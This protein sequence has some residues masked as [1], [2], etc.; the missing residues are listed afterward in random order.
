[1]AL[2]IAAIVLV[3]AIVLRPQPLPEAQALPA[4][5]RSI[6]TAQLRPAAAF[7][8]ITDPAVRSVALFE[9]AGRVIQHPRCMNC[10]PR[11]DRPTQTDA[12]RPH[13]PW[14]TR[15]PDNA[16]AA[17]LRCTTCHHDANFAASGVPGNPKW[18]LAPIEMAWQG[19]TL[20]QICRQILDPARAHMGRDQLLQHMAK[21]EL[22]GWAWHPG[23]KRTPAP[24]TQ[25]E[26]GALIDAWLK[27]GAR[28]PA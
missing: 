20:G 18:K 12:M 15:G 9:E 26:F 1:M 10:H 16:G 17:T 23:G 24:G 2:V 25:A 3:L 27:T 21:D 11:T 8:T 4:N 5:H 13:M 28:C 7:A 6:E 19:K 22:V 14:V